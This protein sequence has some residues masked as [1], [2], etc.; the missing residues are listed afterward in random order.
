M[1][2]DSQVF[3]SI[4][5]FGVKSEKYEN[6][7]STH[8]TNYTTFGAVRRAMLPHVGHSN[9]IQS[10]LVRATQNITLQFTWV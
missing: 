3:L 4:L 9:V 2:N 1:F 6:K 5:G 10:K 8:I 7:S